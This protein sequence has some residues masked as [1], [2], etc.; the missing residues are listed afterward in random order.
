[1]VDYSIERV[2][3]LL[4]AHHVAPSHSRFLLPEQALQS[5]RI[6]V[7]KVTSDPSHVDH[8]KERRCTDRAIGHRRSVTELARLVPTNSQTIMRLG[9]DS[10][11]TRVQTLLAT[12]MIDEGLCNSRRKGGTHQVKDVLQRI[13]QRSQCVATRV[14]VEL[15]LQLC[16]LCEV[17][18]P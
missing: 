3:L 4:R 16:Q 17:E 2:P 13:L 11:A 14:M 7:D 10:G 18:A 9:G 8:V 5:Q 6:Q 15:H 12:V 1:M